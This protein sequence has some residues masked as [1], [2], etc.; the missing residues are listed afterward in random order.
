[1]SDNETKIDLYNAIGICHED[2]K[3]Y[4]KAKEAYEK[5]YK[6]GSEYA[7]VRLGEIYYYGNGVTQDF[8]KALEY[9]E[10]AERRSEAVFTDRDETAD[11]AMCYYKKDDF[12]NAIKWFEKAESI[13][14]IADGEQLLAYGVSILYCYEDFEKAVVYYE[15][16]IAT[17]NTFAM[18][19]LGLI[20]ESGT[21]VEVDY[22]KAME[23]YQMSSNAGNKYG[24]QYLN[25]LKE[26]LS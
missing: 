16:S 19:A 4:T 20:Y 1:M 26:K 21:C 11:F 6:Y 25:K 3:E 15:K 5:A 12:E 8:D 9:Y 23:Y 2:S 24:E 14:E 17:G 10:V 13:E 7:A 18:N 22:Q